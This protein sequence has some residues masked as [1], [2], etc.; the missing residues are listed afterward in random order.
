MGLKTLQI[1]LHDLQPYYFFQ[2]KD[3]NGAVNITGATIRATMKDICTG[4]LKINRATNR[5]TVTDATNGLAE[6]RWLSG[7][8]NV[9]GVYAVEFEIT[10]GSGGKFTVHFQREIC[11][12]TV[13]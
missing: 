9:L 4:T 10:P 12:W 3:S 1:V 2:V 7:D 13:K 8:T 5:V 11:K 6:L